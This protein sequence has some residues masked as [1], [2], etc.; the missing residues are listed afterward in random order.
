[1]ESRYQKLP[2]EIVWGPDLYSTLVTFGPPVGEST[3]V[4]V[5]ASERMT[6]FF[7]RNVYYLKVAYAP[8]CIS[9]L[10]PA[11]LYMLM[12]PKSTCVSR[13]LGSTPVDLPGCSLVIL[14]L[15]SKVSPNQRV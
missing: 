15:K 12:N 9:A 11:T 10:A 13:L 1:M 3:D 6:G 2:Y 4:V 5:S 7:L 8:F 14:N